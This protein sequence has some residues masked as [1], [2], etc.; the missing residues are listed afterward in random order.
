MTDSTKWKSV[1]VPVDIHN[2]IKDLAGI[3][4][5]P[6]NQALEYVVGKAWDDIFLPKKEAPPKSTFRSRA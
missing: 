4:R 2:K 1:M 5:L 3:H 6:I